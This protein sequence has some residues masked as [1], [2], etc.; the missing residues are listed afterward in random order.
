[1]DRH[2]IWRR[3]RYDWERANERR[4]N[5]YHPVVHAWI[6]GRP[7]P[8]QLGFVTTRRDRDEV[9]IRLETFA[10]EAAD[11]TGAIP[12]MCSW[13][14]IPESALLGVEVSYQRA[15]HGIGFSYS[16]FDDDAPEE[17]AA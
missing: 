9:R 15:S 16:E 7:E 13:I 11:G 12:P 3:V 6:A 4:A 5:G 10:P 2:E 8:V 14:H 17:L 1:M